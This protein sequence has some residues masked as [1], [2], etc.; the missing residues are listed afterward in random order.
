VVCF[1]FYALRWRVKYFIG[2][3]GMGRVTEINGN[4]RRSSRHMS[5]DKGNVNVYMFIRYIDFVI[6]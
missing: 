5:R 6:K 1:S 4:L 3:D 2:G